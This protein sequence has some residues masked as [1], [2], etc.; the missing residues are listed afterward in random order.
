VNAFEVACGNRLISQWL[1]LQANLT[2]LEQY[3]PSARW[4][5]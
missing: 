3:I 1:A 2:I 4:A 5:S